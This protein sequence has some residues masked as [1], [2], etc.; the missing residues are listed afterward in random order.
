MRHVLLPVILAV[1]AVPPALRGDAPADPEGLR[2]QSL[3]K[4][5]K[6]RRQAAEGLGILG[7]PASQALLQKLLKDPAWEV[8]ISAVRSLSKRKAVGASQDLARL[9]IE[10]EVWPLRLEAARAL[11]VVDEAQAAALLKAASAKGGPKKA[12]EWSH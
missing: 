1:L 3:A 4:D 9:A 10:G 8:Q 7:D 2:K 11:G 6:E 12:E 5:W